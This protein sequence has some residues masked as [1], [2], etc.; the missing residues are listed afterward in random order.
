MSAP[1]NTS[2]IEAKAELELLLT[3]ADQGVEIRKHMLERVLGSLKEGM[4]S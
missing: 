1:L 2:L 4:K 3:Y